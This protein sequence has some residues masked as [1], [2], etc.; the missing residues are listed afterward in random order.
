M[1]RGSAGDT[2]H[3]RKGRETED[4]ALAFLE[5]HGL[6]CIDR[7]FRT[8]M[9]EIDLI[10]DEKGTLVFVEVRYR[11]DRRFGGA[12]A[13]IDQRKQGRLLA[14]ARYYLSKRAVD[15]PVRFDVIAMER[16]ED[17]TAALDWIK[18]AIREN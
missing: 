10:M 3:L 15:R 14:A 13:S 2:E 1:G 8:R 16:R 7:N 18:D 6:T 12:L 17:G 5:Q 9:G 4:Q 11:R